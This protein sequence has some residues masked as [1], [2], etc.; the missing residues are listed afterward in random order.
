MDPDIDFAKFEREFDTVIMGRRTFEIAGGGGEM[1]TIVCSRTLRRSDHPK[2][3]IANDAVATVASLKAA[4]GKD[5][6]LFG[7]GDLFRSLLDAKLVDTIE[8]GVIPIMLGEGIAVLPRGPRSPALRLEEH[9]VLP[10]GI[11]GLT[12][13]LQYPFRKRMRGSKTG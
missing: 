4:P 2:V 3:T 5:I 6:W 8:L 7:G 9:K 10:S 1:Q 12:Y 11:V 13:S